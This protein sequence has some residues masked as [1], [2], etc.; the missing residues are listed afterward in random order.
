MIRKVVLAV[1]AATTIAG[2]ALAAPAAHASTSAGIYQPN[3]WGRTADRCL[4]AAPSLKY[5]AQP[6]PNLKYQA[7][8]QPGNVWE[9]GG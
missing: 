5:Q 1:A 8:A 9:D 2:G 4:V 3:C 7:Q 6:P